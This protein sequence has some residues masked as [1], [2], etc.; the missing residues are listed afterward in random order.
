MCDRHGNHGRRPAGCHLR[1]SSCSS[2]SRSGAQTGSPA[3][4]PPPAGS[5]AVTVI[6]LGPRFWR[7]TQWGVQPRLRLAHLRGFGRVSP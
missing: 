7:Q 6:A 5:F 3:P 2:E 4:P 1:L